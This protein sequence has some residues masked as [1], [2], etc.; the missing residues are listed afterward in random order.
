MHIIYCP[1][2]ADPALGCQKRVFIMKKFVFIAIA[3][4]VAAA[5]CTKTETSEPLREITFQV[6]RHSVLSKA[7]TDYKDE[8][9]SVPFG[10]YAWFK[11]VSAA[12]NADFMTN[13]EVA[14]VSATNQ[15]APSGTTY[16]WPKSGK[17]DFICYSPYTADGTN[18]PKPVVTE[19][20]ISYPA[21][22]VNAYPGVDVMYADK[23][24]GLTANSNTYYYN[25]VPTLFHHAL[26]KVSFQISASYLEK[27]APTGDK[28]RWEI[29]VN[30]VVVTGVRTTGTLDLTLNPDGTWAK[31]A[32]NIWS[33]DGS[34]TT[35]LALN[36]SGLSALS[37]IPQ[38]LDSNILVLPQALNE[39]QGVTLNVNIKTYR[40]QNDG[41][42]E[43]LILTETG[44][45]VPALLS[46]GSLSSWG[47]NQNITYKFT[48][49]PSTSG[50]SV[51]EPVAI[52]FDPAVADWENVTVNA[53]VNL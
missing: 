44:I 43:H 1:G 13:Q 12:D 46:G 2:A 50:P 30:S 41:T 52:Y 48:L 53:D 51:D 7:N 29:T 15:W 49:S 28:T 36:V 11:G 40:D 10:A 19:T 31:P 8:Y 25:G 6:A 24:T 32:S 5:A 38:N 16:Y 27:T 35:D 3:A 18:A 14:Y 9:S 17:L 23:V 22:D 42:G 26:A 39:G 47:I 45:D 20:G 34:S 33:N 4:L 21:W 37:E